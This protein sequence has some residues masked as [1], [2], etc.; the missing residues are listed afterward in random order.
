MIPPPIPN[1]AEIDEVKNEEKISISN[2]IFGD[3]CFY[4]RPSYNKDADNWKNFKI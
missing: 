1:T 2:S 3:N 4:L